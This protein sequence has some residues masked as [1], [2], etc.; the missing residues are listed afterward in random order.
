MAVTAEHP[1]IASSAPGAEAATDRADPTPALD[2]PTD[3]VRAAPSAGQAVCLHPLDSALLARLDAFAHE[4]AVPA[5]RPVLLAY[6][7]VLARLSGQDALLVGLRAFDFPFD[8]SETQAPPVL[9][10]VLR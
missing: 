3:F 8:A 7:V 5:Q 2:L 6:Q 9:W 1:S 10:R 4:V